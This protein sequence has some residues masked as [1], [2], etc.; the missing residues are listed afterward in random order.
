VRRAPD[1]EQVEHTVDINSRQCQAYCALNTT[2]KTIITPVSWDDPL[3]S[4][5]DEQTR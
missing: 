2:I 4:L 5:T 3:L 1:D